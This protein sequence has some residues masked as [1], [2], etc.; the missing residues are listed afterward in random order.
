MI[1]NRRASTMNVKNVYLA[2]DSAH[3]QIPL[4][5]MGMNVGME[6][7]YVFAHLLKEDRLSE[8]NS[9]RMPVIENFIRQMDQRT[10]ILEHKKSF[11]RWI[12]PYLLKIVGFFVKG[13]VATFVSGL[14]HDIPFL[15]SE[16]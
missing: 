7:A 10:F 12:T 4:G 3:A 13:R 1:S 15:G 2:G 8:Y 5:G 6:D 9:I 11:K 14:D 16:I